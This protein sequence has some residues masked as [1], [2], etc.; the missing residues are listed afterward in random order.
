M[1]LWCGSVVRFVN[2][3]RHKFQHDY[4]KDESVLRSQALK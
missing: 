2:F 1:S 3:V 4:R